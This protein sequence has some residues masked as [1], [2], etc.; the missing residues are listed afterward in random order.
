MDL[1]DEYATRPLNSVKFREVEMAYHQY[2]QQKENGKPNPH[3][4]TFAFV[5]M[6]SG[7]FLIY[8]ELEQMEACDP[9]E[10]GGSAINEC[11]WEKTSFKL[12]WGGLLVVIVSLIFIRWNHLQKKYKNS[13]S[14]KLET[15]AEISQMPPTEY[16]QLEYIRE[17]RVLRYVESILNQD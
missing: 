12:K 6:L 11:E 7:I 9:D 4:M 13:M 8:I 10:N 15:L 14:P 5:I 16:D 1:E 2:L 3:I 17:M